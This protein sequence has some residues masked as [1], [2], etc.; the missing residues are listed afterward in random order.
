MQMLCKIADIRSDR[1]ELAQHLSHPEIIVGLGAGRFGV[2][3]L[4][5][6]LAEMHAADAGIGRAH[7]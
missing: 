1:P 5:R 2:N 6:R 3:G 4:E 7:V